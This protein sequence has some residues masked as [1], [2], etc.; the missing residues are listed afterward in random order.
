MKE[1]SFQRMLVKWSNVDSL[2]N[3]II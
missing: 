2:G 1:T 3:H